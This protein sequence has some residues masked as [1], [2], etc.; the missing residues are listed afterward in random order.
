M[1]VAPATFGPRPWQTV[2]LPFDKFWL[3]R[4]GPP[5][6]APAEPVDRSHVS[7][8]GFA[9]EGCTNGHFLIDGFTLTK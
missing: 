5:S 4:F 2:S 8:F 7:A 6:K 9:P 1:S 3:N